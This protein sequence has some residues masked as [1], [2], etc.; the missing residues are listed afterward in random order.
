MSYRPFFQLVQLG[1]TPEMESFRKI[2]ETF[3]LLNTFFQPTFPILHAMP[4]NKSQ[5]P[6]IWRDIK[7][8]GRE[9]ISR[10]IRF[11]NGHGYM[12]RHNTV[13]KYDI[14]K[15]EADNPEE[16]QCRLFEEHEETPIH[17]ITECGALIHERKD[18][19][20]ESDC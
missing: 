18:L 7:D 1:L 13:F 11:V 6:K 10:V 8:H 20:S 12:N 15:E 9:N 2:L 17:L 5:K 16:A 3:S 4:T 14:S 19:F